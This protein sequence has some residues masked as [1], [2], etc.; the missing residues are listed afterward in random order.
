MRQV[1]MPSGR[2]LIGARLR[3]ALLVGVGVAAV[4][5]ALASGALAST[6]I[7]NTPP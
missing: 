7:G 6:T 2:A 3:R 1:C 5:L 4:S